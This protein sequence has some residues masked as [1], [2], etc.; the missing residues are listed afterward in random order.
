MYTSVQLQSFDFMELGLG[1]HSV[2]KI[3][4]D[5]VYNYCTQCV[6]SK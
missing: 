4:Y 2:L 5:Y 1:Q 3:V 6:W